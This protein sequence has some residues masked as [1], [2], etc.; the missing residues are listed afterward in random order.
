MQPR[1][2][3][4][5]FRDYITGLD[6]RRRAFLSRRPHR[7]FRRTVRRDYSRSLNLPGY[8]A[9]T[10]QVLKELK[11]HRRT[12]GLLVIFYAL[13]MILLGGITNQEN[14]TQINQLLE[15]S[16]STLTE[17]G[18]DKVGQAGLLLVA[19]FASG[20]SNLSAD[21][22]VYLALILI[23]VW[24]SIV[25]MLREYKLG[26]KPKLRDGLYNSGAPFISTLLVVL[27]MICQL[28]PLGIVA[29][30]Y[31]A[32]TSVGII[33][34]GFGSMLF[35]VVASLIACLVLYW[36][37]STFI[38]LV[39]VTL[40]GMYPMRA[41]K[42]SSDIVVGRRLRI[43]YR[44]LWALGTVLLSWLLVMIPLVLLTSW[45][46]SLLPWMSNIAIMP[47]AVALMTSL[48]IVWM[49]SYIYILYRK[50][51]DDGVSPA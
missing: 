18:L 25:W 40:P 27:V 21:Q 5:V 12:L 41:L 9:F 36:I 51:V 38:G 17:G 26:R 19:T 29:L 16:S 31:A 37:T 22:Q 4:E 7:S 46:T 15:Q 30:V 44:M 10:L 14:Y 33:S 48:T 11:V 6:I 42:A 23:F 8:H 1:S 45:L 24:L 49:A 20:P 32:L 34:S 47:Y 13:L 2:R 39:V 28:L 50:V 3:R 35:W 43:M